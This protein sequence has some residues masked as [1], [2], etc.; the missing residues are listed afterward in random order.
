MGRLSAVFGLIAVAI[1]LAVVGLAF[2]ALKWLL[3]AA[4]VVFLLG[5]LRA[6]VSSRDGSGRGGPGAR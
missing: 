2:A 4:A 5:V 6:L 3:I 1:V